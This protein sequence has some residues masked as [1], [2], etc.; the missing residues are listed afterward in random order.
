MNGNGKHGHGFAAAVGLL[1][2]LFAG[3]A[4]ILRLQ[5]G[6]P[7]RAGLADGA[8]LMAATCLPQID[9]PVGSE[10]SLVDPGV[11]AARPSRP[12]TPSVL[13]VIAV[14]G[15]ALSLPVLQA[16]A[17]NAIKDIGGYEVRL[18][19]A[20]GNLEFR[21]VPGSQGALIG[22]RASK[23]TLRQSARFLPSP[24]AVYL[25]KV[26]AGIQARYQGNHYVVPAGTVLGRIPLGDA[27]AVS[28]LQ[29]VLARLAIGSTPASLSAVRVTGQS[30]LA[31]LSVETRRSSIGSA[32]PGGALVACAQAGE[33]SWTPVAASVSRP[34]VV[35]VALTDAHLPQGFE[36]VRSVRIAVAT[37]D[38]SALA[39]GGLNLVGRAS[40]GV[41]SVLL[42][43][44]LLW[45]VMWGRAQQLSTEDGRRPYGSG[46][47]IGTD[48]D[49][50]LSLF[51][52]FFWTV[53]TVW[54]YVYVFIVAGDLLSLS[55]GVMALLGIAGTGTVLA[56]WAAVSGRSSSLDGTPAKT[57]TRFWSMLNTNGQ[58]DLLKLQ[59]FVF[60]VV[61]G[62]YV[63]CRIAD[64]AAFPELDT[65]TLL[66]LGVS[67]GVYITG[68]LVGH[69]RLSS[70]QDLRAEL[71]VLLEAKDNLVAE[72]SSKERD[73]A[74]EADPE[75]KKRLETE[76]QGLA[77][78][79]AEA[80][81]K[82][83]DISA[84]YEKSLSDMRL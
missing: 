28:T 23:L 52:I 26:D 21:L 55:A 33:G 9:I 11:D 25:V 7:A 62:W 82:I 8:D 13:Q 48:N 66:L 35:D 73:V 63:V 2:L 57:D 3:V 65:N 19:R 36:G 29:P 16:P 45:L 32:A 83:N 34:G 64:A 30:G 41:I 71:D 22:W 14:D 77:A 44:T 18:T 37:A 49:P 56:R 12:P 53:I 43:A 24:S 51:Q 5:I 61:I 79:L 20:S 40:A 70:L 60:T 1:L 39:V 47:F 46:L 78:R 17:E 54:G 42:T 27:Q 10:I 69:S 59:L 6:Q 81:A 50:S 74:N 67:Q 72:K 38:G 15:L 84:R 76:V 58:F 75:K 68:K 31:D 4:G 80:E